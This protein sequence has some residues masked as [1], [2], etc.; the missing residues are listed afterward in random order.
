MTSTNFPTYH[1]PIATRHDLFERPA[2]IPSDL[3]TYMLTQLDHAGMIQFCA[4]QLH[5]Q[6]LKLTAYELREVVAKRAA[7]IAETAAVVAAAKK[8]LL[9]G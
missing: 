4:F 8:K 7:R 5:R 2:Y 9:A 6:T 3:Y 1:A